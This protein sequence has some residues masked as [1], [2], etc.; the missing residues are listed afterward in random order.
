[1]EEDLKPYVKR[2]R[3]RQAYLKKKVV[4]ILSAVRKDDTYMNCYLD[5]QRVP[6]KYIDMILQKLNITLADNRREAIR[7]APHDCIVPVLL[8]ALRE[9]D[10][11]YQAIL[12]E[13][14]E[15]ME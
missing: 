1:M 3:Q 9:T 5:N 6:K 12:H 13:V 15:L 10:E 4:K 14:H 8:N 2:L 7:I 11:K